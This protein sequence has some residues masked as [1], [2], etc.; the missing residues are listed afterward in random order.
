[1]EGAGVCWRVS[2]R[3]FWAEG[4]G[5][6]DVGVGNPLVLVSPV[7]AVRLAVAAI[8]HAL[9]SELSVGPRSGRLPT[10][11]GGRPRRSN[12]VKRRTRARHCNQF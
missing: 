9:V 1:M 12:L 2:T 11:W 3:R 5:A 4:R 6:C 8:G 7:A 10:G